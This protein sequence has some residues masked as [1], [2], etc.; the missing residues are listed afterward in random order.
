MLWCATGFTRETEP[1]GDT[2]TDIDTNT[3]IYLIYNYYK[4]LAHTIMGVRS[5]R[6]EVSKLETQWCKFQSWS[7]S[8]GRR[9]LMPQL[10]DSQ[11]ERKNPLLLNLLFY[12]HFQQIG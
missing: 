3:V 8:E 1:I 6:S 11:A 12:S 2:D 9:S 10:K 7:E 4:E 5:P